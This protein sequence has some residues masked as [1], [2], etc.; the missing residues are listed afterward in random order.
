M[1]PLLSARGIK[2]IYP[3]SVALDDVD[4]DVYPGRINALIGENGAGKS[5]LMKIIAGAE[6]ATEGEIKVE[7]NTVR[8]ASTHEAERCGIGIIFQE[9]NIFP[10]LSVAENIFIAHE[11]MSNAFSIDHKKQKEIASEILRRLQ[12][13]IDPDTMAGNLRIGQQQI[14]EIARALSHDTK[15]LI[16]DEPTSALSEQEVDVLF[17]G[18]GE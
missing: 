10:N 6:T 4:F 13:N 15:I 9:L 8:Y 12:Q 11:R 7:G 1:K 5:T 3:G 17:R 16:M 18:R 2:K 14:V